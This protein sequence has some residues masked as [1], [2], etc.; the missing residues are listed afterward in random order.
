METPEIAPEDWEDQ[1]IQ[2]TV[3][4]MDQQEAEQFEASLDRCRA[5]T[6]L[7]AT[8]A[9]IA[10]LLASTAVPSEPPAGHRARFMARIA[11]TSH[12][13]ASPEPQGAVPRSPV[14]SRRAPLAPRSRTL[15]LPWVWATA[16]AAVLTVVLG[17]WLV[18]VLGTVAEQ[19]AAVA[20]TQRELADLRQQVN[21]PP[22]YRALALAPTAEYT[23]VSALVLY[24]PESTEAWL[25]AD[26]LQPLPDDLIYEL[27]LIRP[28]GEGRSDVGGTFGPNDAGT[29]VHRTEGSRSITAYAGFAVSIERKPGVQ[30]RE[31]PVVVVGRFGG[32]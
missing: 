32:Q 29:A 25:V 16:V 12:P 19:K 13:A 9:Q 22:G 5:R 21:I 20:E 6:E 17:A 18:S 4:A 11:A 24:N 27:W 26:G 3:S 8:Y 30:V 10:G 28:P 31:G 1:L 15:A 7:A 2:F 23:G 14:R